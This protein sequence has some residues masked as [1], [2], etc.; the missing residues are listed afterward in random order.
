MDRNALLLYLRDLRDLEIAKRKIKFILDNEKQIFEQK[1]DDL[2]RAKFTKVPDKE[3]GWT[4]GRIVGAIFF[5]G[6]GLLGTLLFV[7]DIF[8]GSTT[9]AVQTRTNKGI[10]IKYEEVPIGK[11][12][13]FIIGAIGSFFL[14]LIG[15][16]IIFYAIHET[17]NNK[18]SI[19]KAQNYNNNE[20]A[21]INGQ[22][23]ASMQIQEQ[24]KQRADFLKS[25]LSKVN[26]LLEQNYNF[27]IIPSQYRNL[28]S[29][30]YIYD[31]MST[32]QE[33]LKD[34]L[35][36]E[37]MK[38]GIQSILQ[39]LD[40]IVE[41]NEEVIFQNRILEANNREIINQNEAMLKSLR[42]TESN[43]AVAAQYAE[44]STYY[45][46]VNAFFNYANYL[47]N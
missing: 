43:T 13:L 8:F 22:K 32:S 11:H 2:S 38:N 15:L 27:N 21:R 19:I 47:Q 12:P 17:R 29:I 10:F 1:F 36:H 3:S 25:E 41:Q 37:H 28:A 33:S 20:L 45:N 16:L 24:W 40:Y 9:R 42:Q 46:K 26:L 5:L 18:K 6:I 44:I 34:T 39:K 31:Y 30:Y 4:I 14:A 7:Y 23:K 35:I